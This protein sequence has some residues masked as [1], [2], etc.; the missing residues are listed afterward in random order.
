MPLSLALY[1][2][3]LMTAFKTRYIA[4]ARQDAYALGRHEFS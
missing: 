3:F 1:V 4:A 2:T